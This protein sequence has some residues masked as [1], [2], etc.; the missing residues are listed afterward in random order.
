MTCAICEERHQSVTLMGA[1]ERVA[2]MFAVVTALRGKVREPQNPPASASCQGWA[3]CYCPWYIPYV[4][5]PPKNFVLYC[6]VCFVLFC[7]QL[8][9]IGL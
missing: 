6:I 7:L 4:K 5:K 2:W 3:L 8:S 1:W 9:D